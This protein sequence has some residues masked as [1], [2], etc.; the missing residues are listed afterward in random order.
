MALI[1]CYQAGNSVSKGTSR[2]AREVT[3]A[4]EDQPAANTGRPE[5]VLTVEGMT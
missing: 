1:G 2:S 4:K 5:Y 3:P